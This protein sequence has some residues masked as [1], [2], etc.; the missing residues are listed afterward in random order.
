MFWKRVTFGARYTSMLLYVHIISIR[1]ADATAKWK[2][3]WPW[4]SNLTCYKKLSSNLKFLQCT[5]PVEKNK[6]TNKFRLFHLFSCTVQIHTNKV[7]KML[8]LITSLFNIPT[9]WWTCT[10]C[11][12]FHSF[13]YIPFFLWWNWAVTTVVCTPINGIINSNGEDLNSETKQ[14]NQNEHFVMISFLRLFSSMCCIQ[15]SE[16]MTHSYLLLLQLLVPLQIPPPPPPPTTLL[17]PLLL[18]PPTCN[19]FCTNCI[20]APKHRNPHSNNY[21]LKTV[22]NNCGVHTG[23]WCMYLIHCHHKSRNCASGMSK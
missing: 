21:C 3:R 5:R 8:K 13:L 18:A 11:L 16:E 4:N 6:K 17:P 12:T 20:H 19:K 10:S 9:C 23:H 1:T 22:K 14:T 15:N 2:G 7:S